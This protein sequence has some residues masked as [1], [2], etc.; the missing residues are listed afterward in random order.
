MVEEEEEFE[1]LKKCLRKIKISDGMPYFVLV[2]SPD[3]FLT[4]I[5]FSTRYTKEHAARLFEEQLDRF[6]SKKAKP[7][8]VCSLRINPNF[9]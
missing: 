6:R 3:T 4:K 2:S 8:Q 7:L 5:D 9:S 1:P